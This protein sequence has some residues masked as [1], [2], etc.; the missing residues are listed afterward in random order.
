MQNKTTRHACFVAGAALCGVGKIL[1]KF[2]ASPLFLCRTRVVV[3]QKATNA[4]NLE[5]SQTLNI[6]L[7]VLMKILTKIV[8]P[9]MNNINHLIIKWHTNDSTL[10]IVDV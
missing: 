10:L 2:N 5:W 3:K 1:V 8:Q 9:F 7:Y 4:L 6:T